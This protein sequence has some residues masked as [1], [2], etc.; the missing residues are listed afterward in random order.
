[1]AAYLARHSSRGSIPIRSKRDPPPI[2]Y[3]RAVAPDS[4]PL[5]ALGPVSPPVQSASSPLHATSKKRDDPK[6]G[7]ARRTEG[8][9][10]S[11][12]FGFFEV[13]I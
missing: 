8:S 6:L 10:F 4:L 7:R 13:G 9:S 1:M 12:L 11:L 2:K 3:T 5:G